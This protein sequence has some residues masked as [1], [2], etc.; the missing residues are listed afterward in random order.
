MIR[1]IKK[2]TCALGV[3]LSVGLC[4]MFFG[5]SPVF[6][7]TQNAQFKTITITNSSFDSNPTSSYLDTSPSGWTPEKGKAKKGIIN[8]DNTKSAFDYN[9]TSSYYLSST[10]NPGKADTAD[11]KVLMVNARQ[12]SATDNTKS[13]IDGFVSDE[14][15]LSSNSYYRLSVWVNTINNGYAS[16]AIT[17]IE[18]DNLACSISNFYHSGIQTSQGSNEWVEYSYYI[19]TNQESQ[20]IKLKLMLGNI[21]EN[22]QTESYGAVFF[23]DV[24]LIE[25]SESYYYS[26]LGNENSSLDNFHEISFVSNDITSPDHNFNFENGLEAWEEFGVYSHSTF[27][28][29]VDYVHRINEGSDY[30]ANNL[31]ALK[32]SAAQDEEVYVGFRSLP[33]DIKMGNIYRISVM[34]KATDVI[35]TVNIN[36]VETDYLK[37]TY[38]LTHE[39]AKQTITFTSTPS[40]QLTNDYAEYAF[41]VYGYELYDTQAQLELTF[42]EEAIPASGSVVFD[43]IKIQKFAYEDYSSLSDSSETY[44]KVKLSTI[45]GTP[46]FTNGAFNSA[47]TSGVQTVYPLTPTDWTQTSSSETSCVFGVVNTTKW[48]E[49]DVK[50]RPTSSSPLNPTFE[51]IDGITVPTEGNISNNILMMYNKTSAIQ[52][53]TSP[54]FTAD[55]NKF[56]AL[57][58]NYYTYGNN[59]TLKI[60]DADKNIVFENTLKSTT[61]WDTYKVLFKTEHFSV[62]TLSLIL[63]LNNENTNKSTYAYFD[64]F[65]FFEKSKM[66]NTAF[67]TAV[68]TGA[69]TVDLSNLGIHQTGNYNNQTSVYEATMFNGTLENGTQVAG[70]APIAFGGIITEKNEYGIEFPDT[71]TNNVSNMLLIKTLAAADY[72]LTSKNTISLTAGEYY[73]F[74]VYVKT[75]FTSPVKDVENFGAYFKLLGIDDAQIVNITNSANFKQYTIYV[76]VD[77]DKDVTVQFGLNS[78]T[79]ANQTACFDTFTFETVTAYTF[80]NVTPSQTLAVVNHETQTSSDDDESTEDAAG[81][82][83]IWIEI[84]T[85]LMIV[86]IMI[87][88]IGAILRKTKVKKLKVKK[89]AEYANRAA[90]FRDAAVIEA[91]QLRNQEIKELIKEKEQLNVELKE[92]ELENKERLA[93]QRKLSGKTITRKAEKEFK[94]Y[95]ANRQK[96]MRDMGRIDDRIQEAQTPEYL[97]R[98]V[99]IVQMEKAKEAD[100]KPSTEN[101][102]TQE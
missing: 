93:A 54:S 43:N 6:A 50:K 57:S 45:T 15:S 88:I 17:G 48:A 34:A 79:T 36:F 69:N 9:C 20:K 63:E 24:S 49:I 11:S 78:E 30:S 59:L 76:T 37:E 75:S 35:G 70:S 4:Q 7:Q 40:N 58:F 72:T 99:K 86:A 81:M 12:A 19:H 8:V 27:T 44:K 5:A 38:N 16:T 68:D 25:C 56:Y 42:G 47:H 51:T 26:L 102:E 101:T 67:Q 14:I 77:E 87:A 91:E 13:T 64:N 28:A 31:K 22:S 62:E 21:S 52:T 18:Q 66:D 85:I 2:I 10:E 97:G 53:V 23:D 84:S 46:T 74:S 96:I 82:G 65:Q 100:K 29:G 60:V 3:A 55:K 73:K 61:A 89:E 95:A 32:I 94:A 71:H 83:N 41:Y 92:L 1:K 98:I 90:M 39:P 80:N 33:F